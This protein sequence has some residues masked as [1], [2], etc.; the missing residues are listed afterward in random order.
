MSTTQK[1]LGDR[2]LI[3]AG[4]H[5]DKIGILVT[6]ER[7]GW[8]VE[9]D[10][11]ERV[12]VSFPMVAVV[13]SAAEMESETDTSHSDS[14]GEVESSEEPGR[15]PVNITP[16]DNTQPSAESDDLDI[17]KMSVKQLQA[18]A[19]Q[20]GIGI[21]RTKDDFLRI[22]KEKNSDEDLDQLKGKTLFHRVGELHISRLRSKQDLV[23]LIIASES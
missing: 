21:A 23:S 20:K 8:T 7:R 17:A 13:R 6:K 14:E 10:D 5:K 22:I 9:L 11:G 18:L 4:P 3:T 16:A 12:A 19:K 15:A 1:Q 2:V